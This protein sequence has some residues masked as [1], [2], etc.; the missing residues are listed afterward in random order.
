MADSEGRGDGPKQPKPAGGVNR[1]PATAVLPDLTD[2]FDRRIDPQR[3]A[4]YDRR[5]YPHWAAPGPDAPLDDAKDLPAMPEMTTPTFRFDRG[6][7]GFAAVVA[8][9]VGRA[10][11]MS[12][13]MLLSGLLLVAA[14][15]ALMRVGSEFL[16]VV[17]L[18][19]WGVQLIGVM[20]ARGLAYPEWAAVWATMA[21][22]I[23]L[24]VP[25]LALQGLLG[26]IP[27]VSLAESSAGPFLAAS[28]GVLAALL[29]SVAVVAVL[30]RQEPE[31]ASILLLPIALI[32]PALIGVPDEAL[33]LGVL[34]PLAA[35]LVA[36]GAWAA[37]MWLAPRGLWLLASPVAL[38]VQ[39]TVLLIRGGG[40]VPGVGAGMVV[41]VGYGAVLA[42][43]AVVSVAMP[44][45]ARWV[46]SVTG[47]RV[48]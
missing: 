20:V 8:K 36:A 10:L 17:M 46:G 34:D 21:I 37:M 7:R 6:R 24:F 38:V 45:L 13:P 14:K 23:G 26:D 16:P 39:F 9:P 43:L 41:A 47:E 11:V 19:L 18:A 29:A 48:R 32:I 35:T 3:R 1:E 5:A 25:L 42:T 28:G 33:A 44:L 15:L 4:E 22:A 27:Y 31:R 40:P 2:L 30:S 12:S